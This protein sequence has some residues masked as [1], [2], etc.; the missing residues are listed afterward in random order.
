MQIN[1]SP[2]FLVA[3]FA[4]LLAVICDWFPP[5]KI[6]Y[7]DLSDIKKRTVMGAGLIVVV[8]LVYGAICV[9]VFATVYTCSKQSLIDLVYMALVAAGINQGVH[10]LTKPSKTTQL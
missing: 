1:I 3:I 6:W 8:A 4:A 5:V 7:D 2:S 9:N 10:N